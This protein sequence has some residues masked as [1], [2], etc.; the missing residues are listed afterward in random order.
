MV[1]VHRVCRQLRYMVIVR[2]NYIFTSPYRDTFQQNLPYHTFRN[3]RTERR[4][5]NDD[6]W[7]RAHTPTENMLKSFKSTSSYHRSV[8]FLGDDN[9]LCLTTEVF[10]SKVNYVFLFLF[11]VGP[12]LKDTYVF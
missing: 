4:I 9:Y 8:I 5:K 6:K 7:P 12:P 2:L 3:W 10:V 11:I 1:E